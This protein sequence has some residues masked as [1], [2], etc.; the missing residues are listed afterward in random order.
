MQVALITITSG[1]HLH[2]RR[3]HGAAR[4][5][6]HQPVRYICVSMGDD[7][8]PALPGLRRLLMPAGRELPLAAARNRGAADA[9]AGAADV[10]V[11]LDVDCIP[12]RGLVAAYLDAIAAVESARHPT[13]ICGPVRYLPPLPDAGMPTDDAEL[14]ACSAEHPERRFPKSGWLDDHNLFW[15]LSFAVSARTWSEL[16]GFCEAYE[17]YG[18]EDTDFAQ[19]L[20][21]AGGR[22]YWAAAAT[23][24]HQHH[25]SHDPPVGHARS[26]VRN[27]ELFRRRWGWYPMR[28]WLE[29]FERRGLAHRSPE[30]GAWYTPGDKPRGGQPLAP[31]QQDVCSP[32]SRSPVE[33]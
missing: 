7:T 14:D 3:Q 22:V 33:R 10:L 20:A 31:T 11:F 17:G 6:S 9:L 8:V 19:R 13:A 18:G 27:A 5:Q 1:R 29:E 16:G 2:L 32:T 21:A 30:S 12:G 28:T 4:H 23:A 25:E 24:Y 15:S 26:I